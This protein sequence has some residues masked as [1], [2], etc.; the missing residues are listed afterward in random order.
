MYYSSSSRKDDGFL[1]AY[2]SF[3]PCCLCSPSCAPQIMGKFDRLVPV[4]ARDSIEQ[5][6][7]N[8]C[9]T[10]SHTLRSSKVYICRSHNIFV[11]VAG[12]N[13]PFLIARDTLTETHSSQP[14][15]E[16]P[17]RFISTPSASYWRAMAP[18]VIERARNLPLQTPPDVQWTSSHSDMTKPTYS[19]NLVYR[20]SGT[21]RYIQTHV[22]TINERLSKNHESFWL[23]LKATEKNG[24]K[25]ISTDRTLLRNTKAV[26]VA[27]GWFL[28]ND[29]L[30]EDSVHY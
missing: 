30:F 2:S 20:R 13:S 25:L 1:C 26:S 15:I 21:A 9:S 16:A 10:D 22:R 23:A 6:M 27:Y 3:C 7:A 14:L 18:P 8:N 12:S 5:S 29:L 11:I 28:E 19:L 24:E 4:R 17:T